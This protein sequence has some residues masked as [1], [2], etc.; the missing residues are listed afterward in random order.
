MQEWKIKQNIYH[1]LHTEHDDDLSKV[2][3]VISNAVGKDALRHFDEKIDEWIYP[4]KSY[5]VA[6]CYAHWISIDF[7]EDFK[8]KYE[9]QNMLGDMCAC[10]RVFPHVFTY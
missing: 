1:R 7:N 9:H 2:D 5:F 10:V 3:I 8:S 4:S 6:I